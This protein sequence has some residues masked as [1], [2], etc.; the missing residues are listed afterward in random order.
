MVTDQLR[1]ER[2]LQTA[3]R[4]CELAREVNEALAAH[5]QVRL[6]FASVEY[7]MPSFTN[8]FVMSVANEAGIEVFGEGV[9]L[10][11]CSERLKA[12]LMKSL[13]RFRAGVRLSNQVALGA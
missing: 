7:M 13:D 3:T 4:G 10:E 12:S 11:N 8:A 6:D 1:L 2:V 5:K 9:V